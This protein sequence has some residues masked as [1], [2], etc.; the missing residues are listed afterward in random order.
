MNRKL[1]FSAVGQDCSLVHLGSTDPVTGQ[2]ASRTS[3]V[4]QR[5]LKC[6]LVGAA[7]ED[8]HVFGHA[9]DLHSRL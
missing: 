2:K 3:H 9:S 6:I 4:G 8:R 7:L 5:L 1:P